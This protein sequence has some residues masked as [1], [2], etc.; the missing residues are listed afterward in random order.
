MWN[1][2][3]W[4]YQSGCFFLDG[5]WVAH[6]NKLKKAEI[7]RG[8]EILWIAHLKRDV[9]HSYCASCEEKVKTSG[10][11]RS[12][13]WWGEVWGCQTVP[14]G[15][16]NG[17]QQEKLSDPAGQVKGLYCGRHPQVGKSLSFC[18]SLTEQGSAPKSFFYIYDAQENT[19]M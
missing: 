17:P 18:C 19:L 15:E 2:Q 10:S 7:P 9:P 11:R 1:K 6:N 12:Q 8:A 4:H 5:S 3:L 14:G 13:A 16:E